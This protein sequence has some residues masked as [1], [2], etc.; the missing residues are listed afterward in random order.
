MLRVLFFLV[1]IGTRAIRAVWRRK[2]ELVMENLAL[3]QQVT[4]HKKERPRPPLDDVDRAFWVALRASWSGWAGLLVIVNADTVARWHRER[5]RRYR[6]KISKRRYP[7]RPRVDAEIREL[8]RKMA[9]D[10]WGAPRIHA[11]LMKLRFAVS[12]MTVSRYMLRRP[13]EPDQVKRWLAFLRNHRH[14]IAAMDL[15]TVPTASLRLLFGFFVIEHGRRHIV[16]F[17]ATFTP[18][19]AWVMQQL[20]NAFPYGSAPRYLIFDRDS[21]FSPAVVEFV[22]ALGIDPVRTSFRSP[23]QTAERWIGNCRREILE[24]VVV[25]GERHLVRLVRLYISYYHEDR[26]HLGL[27]KDTPTR[28]RSRRHRHPRPRSWRC[29][30]WVAYTIATSGGKLR[31]AVPVVNVAWHEA[32]TVLAFRSS[33]SAANVTA[34]LSRGRRPCFSSSSPGRTSPQSRAD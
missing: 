32:V 5:F 18:T 2:A 16:H 15:F 26:C 22:R 1:S 10:G 24:H 28:D 6:A 17:N 9:K 25:F 27:G 11:E 19:A 34:A 3:R 20:R 21:I 7:G 29:L 31:S 4:A 13:L 8:I 14:D 30:E 33:K 12:E 23:W